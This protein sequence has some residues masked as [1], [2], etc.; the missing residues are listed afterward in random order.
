MPAVSIAKGI[1]A[2][3]ACSLLRNILL[4]ELYPTFKDKKTPNNTKIT[5][6][7]GIGNAIGIQGRCVVPRRFQPAPNGSEIVSPA[8]HKATVVGSDAAVAENVIKNASPDP[9]FPRKEIL[10]S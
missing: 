10:A 8:V 1:N 4:N 5:S 6:A 2:F 7:I 3:T 9:S